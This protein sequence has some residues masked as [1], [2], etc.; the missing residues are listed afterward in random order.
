M[1]EVLCL[2]QN[3]PTYC[4]GQQLIHAQ[5]KDTHMGTDDR[6][7]SEYE[8][9]CFTNRDSLASR[10]RSLVYDGVVDMVNARYGMCGRRCYGDLS[11]YKHY[12]GQ[13]NAVANPRNV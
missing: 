5:R 10:D 13:S 12:V 11:S 8:C 1:V 6:P 3:Y 4:Y 7:L 9:E 2:D